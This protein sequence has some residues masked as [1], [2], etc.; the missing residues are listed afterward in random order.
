M[1]SF[2]KTGG[3]EDCRIGIGCRHFP[4]CRA[5]V[6]DGFLVA[7]VVR[8]A[9]EIAP[10][11]VVQNGFCLEVTVSGEPAV[12]RI[13]CIGVTAE[14]P[15]VWVFYRLIHCFLERVGGAENLSEH[16]G[17]VCA[18]VREDAV[19]RYFVGCLVGVGRIAPTLNDI[20]A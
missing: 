4:S 5:R 2:G 20:C 13:D 19:A 6:V 3:C 10:L 17:I 1:S 9:P 16:T 7:D 11:L 14:H 8:A 12:L 15:F 18:F